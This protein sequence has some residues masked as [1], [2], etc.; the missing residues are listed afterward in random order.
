[1]AKTFPWWPRARS[2]LTITVSNAWLSLPPLTPMAQSAPAASTSSMR[3][4][5]QIMLYLLAKKKD[6]F[7]VLRSSPFSP[8]SSKKVMNRIWN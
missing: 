5:S 2:Q 6:R 7:T 3:G 4:E 8:E 1:M